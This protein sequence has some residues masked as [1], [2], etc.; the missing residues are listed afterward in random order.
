MVAV[1]AAVGAN[2]SA[3]LSASNLDPALL[4]PA[5]ILLASRDGD[6]GDF[7]SEGRLLLLTI[8]GGRLSPL[9]PFAV[10]FGSRTSS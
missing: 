10:V 4:S 6:S 5:L 9:P 1:A 2:V 7:G 3:V 8:A